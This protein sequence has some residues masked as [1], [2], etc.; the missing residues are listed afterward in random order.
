MNPAF[1]SSWIRQSWLFRDSQAQPI[2]TVGYRQ[3]QPAFTTPIRNLY[4]INTTHIY[5]EDRGTNYA[6]RLGRQVA[7]LMLGKSDADRYVPMIG[8]GHKPRPFEVVD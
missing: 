2:I 6:V 4:L 7:A 8:T 5:P 1:D 3:L